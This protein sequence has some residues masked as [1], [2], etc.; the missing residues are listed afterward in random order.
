MSL[1]TN[2]SDRLRT[3]GEDHLL[4]QESVVKNGNPII[5]INSTIGSK[6]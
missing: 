2:T 3:G 6:G 5:P 4:L 1:K